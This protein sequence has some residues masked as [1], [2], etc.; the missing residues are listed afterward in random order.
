MVSMAIGGIFGAWAYGK[1]IA[2]GKGVHFNS[3]LPFDLEHI[4]MI[5]TSA[6]ACERVR[7]YPA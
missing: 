1:P 3:L 5:S 7:I 4:D 2:K 6:D